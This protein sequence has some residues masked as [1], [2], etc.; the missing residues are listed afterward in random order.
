[1]TILVRD[2]GRNTGRQVLD[3]D[4]PEFGGDEEVCTLGISSLQGCMET[5]ANGRLIEVVTGTVDVPAEMMRNYCSI[6]L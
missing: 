5:V 2:R 3:M 4:S 6:T 1:M